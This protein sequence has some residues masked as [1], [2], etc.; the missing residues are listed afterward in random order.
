[1]RRRR[2]VT[3]WPCI[4]AYHYAV[5]GCR[6]PRR[7]HNVVTLYL[8]PA[9]AA[10]VSAAHPPEQSELGRGVLSGRLTATVLAPPDASLAAALAA[11]AD[12][13]PTSGAAGASTLAL[14]HVLQGLHPLAELTGSGQQRW[15]N[16]SLTDAAC[17]TALQTVISLNAPGA[18]GAG[19][20]GVLLRGAAATARVSG[21]DLVACNSLVHLLDA[22]LPPCCTSLYVALPRFSVV[23]ITPSYFA[24]FVT[25]PLPN[26]DSSNRRLFEEAMIDLLLVRL[27]AETPAHVVH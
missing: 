17:P 2:V 24:G 4:H 13:Q 22:A 20:P 12:G 21:G 19:A 26:D 6:F 16:T 11:G 3:H 1:M 27:D 8:H 18:G 5:S 9:P 15:L 7:K 10:H 23:T 14:Y 25:A